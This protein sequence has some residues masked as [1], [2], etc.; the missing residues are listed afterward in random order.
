MNA[1]RQVKSV[2]GRLYYAT[3]R[4][5]TAFRNRALVTCFHSINDEQGSPIACT[6]RQFDEYCAFFRRYFDTLTLGELLDRLEHGADI[7]GTAVI[8]FDDGYRDNFTLA[9]PTLERYGLPATFFLATD[10]IGSEHQA[11]WDS[12][13][14]IESRWMSW[15]Q[16]RTLSA[17]A[18]FDVGAHTRSHSDLGAISFDDAIAEIDGSVNAIEAETAQRPTLFAYPFG[19]TDNITPEVRAH[20]RSAGLR[21]CPSAFGGL[22]TPD[23]DPFELNRLPIINWYLSAYQFG[24]EAARLRDRP[25]VPHRS[26]AAPDA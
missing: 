23:V 25:F 5:R 9:A 6:S 19:G 15:D 11:W 26:R 22:V 20:V 13:C 16:V 17:S 1:K 3:G 7:S 4:H 18:K 2:L 21:C 12:D 14:G 8:T 10:F 24:F